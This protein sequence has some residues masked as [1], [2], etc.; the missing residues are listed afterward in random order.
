MFKM[1]TLNDSS[2]SKPVFNKEELYKILDA[3]L[4]SNNEIL[5]MNAE[6]ISSLCVCDDYR[7]ETNNNS[8]AGEEHF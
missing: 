3:I 1:I 8:D 2:I 5:R 4:R 7:K 6:L